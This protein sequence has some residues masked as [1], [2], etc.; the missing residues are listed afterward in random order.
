[1][2]N[3]PS[4]AD[5]ACRHLIISG[6]VQGVSYRASMVEAAQAL[7]VLGWV[8]NRHDGSVEAV[9][10]G[11]GEAVAELIGWARHGPPAAQ[12]T[13]VRVELVEASVFQDFRALPTA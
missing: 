3:L 10:H 1:M 6:R 4:A 9:L 5:L 11:S 8:R 12:V 13:Q 2:K 7:G